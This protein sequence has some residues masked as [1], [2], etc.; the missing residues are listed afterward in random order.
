MAGPWSRASAPDDQAA[1]SD[2]KEAL[3]ALNLEASFYQTNRLEFPTMYRKAIIATSAIA[4]SAAAVLGALT[5][6]YARGGGNDAYQTYLDEQYARNHPEI[7]PGTPP[8]I[9]TPGS[10]YGFAPNS[11]DARGTY[12]YHPAPHARVTHEAR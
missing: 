4:L 8:G 9:S 2:A 10:A 3:D 1:A 5:P 12:A 7:V 11:P 6:A